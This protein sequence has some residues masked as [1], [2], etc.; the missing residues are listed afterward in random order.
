MPE[1]SFIGIDH[2]DHHEWVVALV[3]EGKIGFVQKFKNTQADLLALVRFIGEHCQRPKIC[4]NPTSRAA[5]KMLKHLGGIPD[6]EVVMMSAAGLKLHRAWLSTTDAAS[7]AQG[8]VEEAVMLA[9]CA[10]RMI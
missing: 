2:N 1:R 5:I 3:T 8:H 4:I 10:Q 9:H 7:P 6:V